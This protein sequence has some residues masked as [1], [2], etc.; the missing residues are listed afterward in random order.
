MKQLVLDHMSEHSGNDN[1][2]PIT[3]ADEML[4]DGMPAPKS[5]AKPTYYQFVTMELKN[6][7]SGIQNMKKLLLFQGSN[8]TQSTS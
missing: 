7:K 5:K 2:L 3:E 4:T 8:Q 6:T 1:S